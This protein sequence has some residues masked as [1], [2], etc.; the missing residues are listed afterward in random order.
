VIARRR[1]RHLR[2]RSWPVRVGLAFAAVLTVASSVAAARIVQ[3]HRDRIGVTVLVAGVPHAV[4]VAKPA[5]VSGALEAADV[6]PRPGRLLSLVSGTVLDPAIRP[7]E[8]LVDGAPASPESPLLAGATIG[9]VEPPDVPEEAVEGEDVIPAPAM[10]TVIHGLWHPGQPGKAVV[11][12]G[13]VSGEVV[14]Q[15]QVQPPVPPVPVTEKLVA[16]TFDDGPWST[17]FEVLRVLREKDVKATFCVV[18]RQM[19]KEGLEATKGALGEGHHLCNHT[20]NHD[21]KLPGRSQKV[22]DQ[23]IRGANQ[24][25]L[26]KVGVKPAYYRPPGGK[27]GPKIEATVKDEGQQVLLWTV[28]TKD[29]QKG[30][31][32]EA[33]IASVMT[34][35]K[36]G[37]VVLMHDGGGDQAA[38]LAALPALIDQLRAAGYQLV[39]PD[40]VPPVTAAPVTPAPVPA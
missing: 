21:G 14:A 36:G 28:D 9:V 33:I 24:Q 1:A 16:L 7:V 37:G 5:T 22:V 8:L 39:L 4:K 29:F 6:V 23:E 17:T 34:T 12:K 10:P 19:K 13:A 2:R 27:M 31:T 3:L 38:T 25:L 20:I 32:P 18:T 40:A 11:R 30:R 15:T 35:V 26:E